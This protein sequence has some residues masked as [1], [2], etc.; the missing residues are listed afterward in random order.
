[1]RDTLK[2]LAEQQGVA[3]H[4]VV[5]EAVAAYR[6]RLRLQ[7][8][9]EALTRLAPE[10]QQRL[11]QEYGFWERAMVQDGLSPEDIESGL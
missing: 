3:M 1:M 11:Q 8:L 7:S 6:D 10:E 5:E 9:N 2:A 4:T